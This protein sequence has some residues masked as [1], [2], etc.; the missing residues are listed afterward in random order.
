M[1][2]PVTHGLLVDIRHCL[3]CHWLPFLPW[4]HTHILLPCHCSSPPA[5]FSCSERWLCLFAFSHIIHSHYC[6]FSS[7]N[8]QCL[9]LHWPQFFCCL[10]TAG[11]HCLRLNVCP[12][13]GLHT[14]FHHIDVSSLVI[15][16]F[17]LGWLINT[18]RNFPLQHNAA[19]Y[20]APFPPMPFRE[21]SACLAMP[22]GHYSPCLPGLPL[23]PLPLLLPA[24]SSLLLGQPHHTATAGSSLTAIAV[25]VS[26][27]QPQ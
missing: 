18:L 22:I 10:F 25:T 13:H 11:C 21:F 16:V 5:S 4:P 6:H 27:C 20:T 23:L 7:H 15:K 24:F 26:C 2:S 14:G 1:P 8:S 19:H 9:L 17:C 12:Y 3:S